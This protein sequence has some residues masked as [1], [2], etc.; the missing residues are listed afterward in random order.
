[1][2][3]DS[4]EVAQ[5]YW[6]AVIR[7]QPWFDNDKEQLIVLLL[8]TR[9]E[10]QGY[11][12]VSIGSV[13]ETIAAPREIFRAAVATSCFAIVVLHNHPSGD[14]SPSEIDHSLTQRLVAAAEVLQIKL[15][16]HVIVSKCSRIRQ[17]LPKWKRARLSRKMRDA[18]AARKRGYFSFREACAL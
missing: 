7:R 14:P 6:K 11:S 10:V 16:D 17:P 9:Y 4:T 12:L 1:M 3:V 8:S 15:L 2:R 13:N 5:R 18:E